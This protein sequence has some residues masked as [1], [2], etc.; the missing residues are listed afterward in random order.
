MAGDSDGATGADDA[1]AAAAAD[2]ST[3]A[4]AALGLEMRRTIFENFNDLELRF[5]NDEVLDVMRKRGV[6][7][8][9]CDV[10]D[11]E[12]DFVSLCKSGLVRNIAQNFN[13]MWLRLF[14]VV[15]E[16]RCGACSQT[17]HLGR[18]EE[19]SCPNPGCGAPLGA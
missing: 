19:R 8:D 18:A 17:V 4:P 15:D 16:M 13:T 7:D 6:V 12:S 9:A 2:S 5:T 11:V 1:P 3:D 14:D 10:C